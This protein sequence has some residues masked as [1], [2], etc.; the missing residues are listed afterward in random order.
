M[1]NVLLIA[2]IQLYFIATASIIHPVMCVIDEPLD[3]TVN[4]I[5]YM[6]IQLDTELYH[7]FVIISIYIAQE[8]TLYLLSWQ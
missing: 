1:N 2:D 5:N 6:N 4:N 7:N 8:T 3:T